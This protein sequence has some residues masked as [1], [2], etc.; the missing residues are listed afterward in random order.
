MFSRAA[1]TASSKYDDLDALWAK[2]VQL[3]RRTMEILPESDL[4]YYTERPK[5]FV[6][7]LPD[8]GVGSFHIFLSMFAADSI[9]SMDAW[10][11]EKNP[12]DIDQPTYA[13]WSI[14]VH[15]LPPTLVVT[16]ISAAE[17]EFPEL[18]RRI[19]EAARKSGIGKMEIW[20]IPKHLLK[21][22]AET[23]GQ[24]F[25]RMGHF[26]AIKWYGAGKTVDIEWVFNEK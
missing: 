8:E 1:Q 18:L 17:S 15:P 2:D 11:V 24:T 7:C 20:N 12:A 3:I 10:G 23:G 5:A 9:V 13:T 16:R 26:P 19:Q 22:A 6:S 4:D 25:E 14:D 21:A